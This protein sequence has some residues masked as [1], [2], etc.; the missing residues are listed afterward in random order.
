MFSDAINTDVLAVVL[1]IELQWLFVLQTE[2][3]LL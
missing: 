1:A 3:M 2:L